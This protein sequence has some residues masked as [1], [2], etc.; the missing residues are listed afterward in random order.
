MLRTLDHQ[1]IGCRFLVDGFQES[2]LVSWV[3]EYSSSLVKTHPL[4][5]HGFGRH[6]LHERIAV[7]R[8]VTQVC[9]I[10][11]AVMALA[12][13][14]SP[15]VLDGRRTDVVE[16]RTDG[17]SSIFISGHGFTLLFNS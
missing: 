2:T 4:A 16:V 17:D 1:E 7:L 14:S 3:E 10:R 8:H 5:L 9:A 12:L 15:H 11:Q 13:G 6:R